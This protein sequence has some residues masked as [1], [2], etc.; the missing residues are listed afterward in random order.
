ME[1]ENYPCLIVS[2]TLEMLRYMI[3][4]IFV[5]NFLFRIILFYIE[6]FIQSY[7]G[8]VPRGILQE[9]G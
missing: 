9:T 3:E 7:L 6:I 8:T 4:N 5:A 1:K 2:E